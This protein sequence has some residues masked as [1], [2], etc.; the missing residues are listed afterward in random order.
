M[1]AK[2]ILSLS[3]ALSACCFLRAASLGDAAA[4]LEIAEWIK[5][6]AVDLAAAKGKKV[7]VVEFW[8]TWC[9][10]CKVSIPHLT[11][12][13][14]KYENRGVVIMAIDRNRATSA[15][16]MEKFGQNGI[17]HAFVIDKEGRIAWHGHPMSGLERVLDQLAS[18]TFDLGLEQKRE[19]ATKK[20]QEYFEMALK[21]EGDEK[22]DKFGVQIAALDKQL[23]G[24]NPEQP[25]DLVG[26]KKMARFQSAMNEYQRA[27]VSGRSDAELAKLEEKAAPLAPKDFSFKD[28]KA[29]FQLQRTFQEYYRAVTGKGDASKSEELAKKLEANP[30][31]NAEMLNEIAWTLLTDEKIKNRNL[32]LATRLALAAVDASEGKDASILDTYAR[33]LFDTGKVDEAI[34]QQKKAVDLSDD[35]DK[36]RELEATLKEYQKKAAK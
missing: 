22:L 27:I 11:E 23:G 33:A 10:P 19:S 3:L 20:I 21:G 14:K 28:F 15:A 5:G 12:M 2:V 34:K 26:L 13:Q 24:I 29:R 16:Y 7:V 1:N 32:K 9:G 25:L 31:D 30:G 35:A 17:P 36:K 4:P 6:D 8:A 18:N